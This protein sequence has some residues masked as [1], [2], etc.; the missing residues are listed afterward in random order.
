MK[1]TVWI[2][3]RG[4]RMAGV[5]EYENDQDRGKNLVVMIHGF[6]ATKVEPHRMFVK[7]S[8]R[9]IKLGFTVLRFDFPGAGDSDGDYSDLTILKEVEDVLNVIEFCKEVHAP[10]KLYLLGFSLGGCVAALSAA[11]LQCDG[12]AIW[13]ATANPFWTFHNILGDEKL[14][15]GLSGQDV[16]FQGELIGHGFIKELQDIDPL[17]AARIYENKVLIIHGSEDT[18]VSPINGLL[19]HQ[20]FP[21]SELHFV[22]EADHCYS[23]VTFEKELLDLTEEYF[24]SF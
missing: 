10:E 1:E 11:R 7:M 4:Y 13:S 19:Y 5:L 20:N 16:D 14:R 6:V 15:A 24:R 2:E 8:A 22:E 12:L 18:D 23:S 21:D 3:S 9:L 17:E